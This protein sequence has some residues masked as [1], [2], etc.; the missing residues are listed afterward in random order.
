MV[1]ET[2]FDI[3][4]ADHESR[5][6]DEDTPETILK[7]EQEVGLKDK[8]AEIENELGWATGKVDELQFELDEAKNELDNLGL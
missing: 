4:D 6:G 8:I 7:M 2:E 1:D 3:M 5:L